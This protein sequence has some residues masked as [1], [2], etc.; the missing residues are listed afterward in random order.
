MI[1]K[2]ICG[3]KKFEI[4]DSQISNVGRQVKCGVCSKEWFYKPEGS[5]EENPSEST[6]ENLTEDTL[7]GEASNENFDNI[8][9]AS[10]SDSLSDNFDL[11]ENKEIPDIDS[12]TNREV[13]AHEYLKQKN[14]TSNS[15]RTR[16]LVYL[17]IILIF[18]LTFLSVP[19]KTTILSIF[20]ELAWYFEGFAVIRDAL[21]K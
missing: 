4:E 6:Q 18:I 7:A 5:V 15:K 1:I 13:G 2:C 20:P 10:T 21:F 16:F 12:S 8:E 19:Y 17:L 11:E 3:L 9:E 14:K